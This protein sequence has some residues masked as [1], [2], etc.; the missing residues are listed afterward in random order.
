MPNQLQLTEKIA[1]NKK[2]KIFYETNRKTIDFFQIEPLESGF[3]IVDLRKAKDFD[4]YLAC[5]PQSK[6]NQNYSE[7]TLNSSRACAKLFI[8]EQLP[9]KGGIIKLI[10]NHSLVLPIANDILFSLKY[11]SNIKISRFS[12]LMDYETSFDSANGDLNVTIFY[13]KHDFPFEDEYIDDLKIKCQEI[14]YNLLEN[15]YLMN[16]YIEKDFQIYYRKA[17]FSE[18]LSKLSYFSDIF[19]E[20]SQEDNEPSKEFLLK[21]Q[22]W[23]KISCF[24]HN[25]N[26]KVSLYYKK[27]FIT[28]NDFVEEVAPDIFLTCQQSLDD[29]IQK[30]PYYAKKNEIIG[31]CPQNC[32]KFFIIHENTKAFSNLNSFPGDISICFSAYNSGIINDFYS[33]FVKFS[34]Y[35]KSNCSSF[36]QKSEYVYMFEPLLGKTRKFHNFPTRNDFKLKDSENHKLFKSFLEV[37]DKLDLGNVPSSEALAKISHIM[38]QNSNEIIKQNQNIEELIKENSAFTYKIQDI[39]KGIQN[40]TG[41]I[42]YFESIV[43]NI[44]EEINLLLQNQQRTNEIYQEK[45]EKMTQETTNYRNSIYFSEDFTSKV[46]YILF[47]L[48]I[49]INLVYQL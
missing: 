46:N 16:N 7:I 4:Y 3:Q 36:F 15:G 29:I 10:N 33:G 9:K 37:S 28:Q 41:S 31:L 25:E 49:L 32:S 30:Y 47:Y 20:I 42:A 13:K 8:N 2:I 24:N 44:K 17:K 19:L 6:N 5:A 22:K 38:N 26:L 14:D 43:L 27:E 11:M 35:C 23:N 45:I 34:P 12:N 39:N 1:E 18:T 21:N 48:K 40:L